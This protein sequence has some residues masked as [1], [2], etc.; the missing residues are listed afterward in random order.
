MTIKNT[1]MKI[2]S[3]YMLTKKAKKIEDTISQT[4]NNFVNPNSENINRIIKI[5]TFLENLYVHVNTKIEKL[6]L[7]E[8]YFKIQNLLSEYYN[9][10]NIDLFI[11]RGNILLKGIC[12]FIY[13]RVS[14]YGYNENLNNLNSTVQ[15]WKNMHDKAE[16]KNV[17]SSSK[18][19]PMPSQNPFIEQPSQLE[20][21]ENM[22]KMMEMFE[23]VGKIK[24]Q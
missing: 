15:Y 6:E 8:S 16:L 1:F 22:Q 20:M 11:E 10:L 18:N 17:L 21:L 23:K 9:Y 7:S 5:G 4:D 2:S 3:V 14:Y 19:I 24:R 12:D 13:D